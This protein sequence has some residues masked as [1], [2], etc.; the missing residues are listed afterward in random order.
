MADADALSA[1]PLAV[2]AIPTAVV[3]YLKACD[4]DP[5][6]ATAEAEAA[7]AELPASAADTPA[8][9]ADSAEAEAWF[10]AVVMYCDALE[11]DD[12][13]CD[14]LAVAVSDASLAIPP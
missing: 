9:L 11:A 6:D 8:R 14:A 7:V 13:A 1:C 3:E 5:A 12:A 10:P 4:A 2:S